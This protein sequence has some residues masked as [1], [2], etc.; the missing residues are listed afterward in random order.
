MYSTKKKG[1]NEV[2]KR[3]AAALDI[4]TQ[5]NRAS[6][7]FSQAVLFTTVVIFGFCSLPSRILVPDFQENYNDL[8]QKALHEPA[9]RFLED[10]LLTSRDLGSTLFA[11]IF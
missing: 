6:L 4:T 9:H 10:M 8:L 11:I 3:A 2:G 1:E 5:G 7:G